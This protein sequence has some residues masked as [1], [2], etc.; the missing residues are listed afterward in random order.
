MELTFDALQKDSGVLGWSR[1]LREPV[2]PSASATPLSVPSDEGG[3]ADASTC[4]AMKAKLTESNTR[5][6]LCHPP[7]MM[8]YAK[9]FK[10]A[11][12]QDG[13]N[14]LHPLYRWEARLL[15]D[16]TFYHSIRGTPHDSSTKPG[17]TCFP[18]ASLMNVVT[19]LN[20]SAP[21]NDASPPRTKAKDKSLS[22][23]FMKVNMGRRRRLA[24][25]NYESGGGGGG[26][27]GC[28]SSGP[29]ATDAS[30]HRRR[31]RR[32][33]AAGQSIFVR[34]SGDTGFGGGAALHGTCTIQERGGMSGVFY[35]AKVMAARPATAH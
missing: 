2:C 27:S 35:S 4:K 1:L 25:G 9:M 21:R 34:E 22:A 30:C 24:K 16:Q 28:V 8:L 32:Q 33:K 15:L 17:A 6:A 3:I 31:G 13:W 19:Q 5:C 12:E 26:G 18:T 29:R 14:T 11:L 23:A 10:L 20:P 7:Q